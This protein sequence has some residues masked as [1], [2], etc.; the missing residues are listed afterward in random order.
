MTTTL[1]TAR[2][3]VHGGRML[4][5]TG[6]LTTWRVG[7]GLNVAGSHMGARWHELGERVC[8][9]F[10]STPT[11]A[12]RMCTACGHLIAHVGGAGWVA[13]VEG[14]SMC[15]PDPDHDG[16]FTDHTPRELVG[17]EWLR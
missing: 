14:M 12:D 5:E 6:V 11:L 15:P 8:E 2:A 4:A 13:V 1:V 17:A 7:G 16:E 3:I 10:G 9:A